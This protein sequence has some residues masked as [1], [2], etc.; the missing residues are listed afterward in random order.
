[1]LQNSQWTNVDDDEIRR[2]RMRN[3]QSRDKIKAWL[4]KQRAANAEDTELQ[5]VGEILNRDEPNDDELE[6]DND[7]MVDEKENEH[8]VLRFFN[9][10]KLN[11]DKI[12]STRYELPGHNSKRVNDNYNSRHHGDLDTSISDVSG[13]LTPPLGFNAFSNRVPSIRVPLRSSTGSPSVVVDHIP[14]P[15]STARESNFLLK[16]VESQ[17]A[18]IARLQA[19]LNRQTSETRLAEESNRRLKLTVDQLVDARQKEMR[20]LELADKVAVELK[21]DLERQISQLKQFHSD[22]MRR[23]EATGFEQAQNLE[24]AQRN[25]DDLKLQLLYYRKQIL[26]LEDHNQRLQFVNKY[27]KNFFQSEYNK[28]RCYLLQLNGLIE[29]EDGAQLEEGDT[30]KL[31]NGSMAEETTGEVID[32]FSVDKMMANVT[33]T[34]LPRLTKYIW[35]V[36]FINRVKN[37]VERNKRVYDTIG[38][39]RLLG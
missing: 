33:G 11:V 38:T 18:E 28:Y 39:A 13:T 19:E 21:R 35:M 32:P 26:Q 9:T 8:S 14:Q 30:T 31:I 5:R 15:T 37:I 34:R 24:D 25:A 1:M 27:T 3:Q 2:H 4:E 7:S 16:R 36:I 10:V 6:M 12:N 23:V 20:R 29:G 22:E 17:E